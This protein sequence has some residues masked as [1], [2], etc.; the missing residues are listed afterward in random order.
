MRAQKNGRNIFLTFEEDVS[1]ALAKVCEF[2]NDSDAIHLAHAA[3]IV[4][5]QM[6]GEAK[7]FTGFSLG[8]QEESVPSLLLT[9][10]TMILGGPSIIDKA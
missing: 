10:V 8:C 6:F 9:L 7:S 5:N 3:K 1:A 2:D 4:H